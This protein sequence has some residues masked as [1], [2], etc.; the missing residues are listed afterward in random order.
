LVPDLGGAGF[1]ALLIAG[2][3]VLV[4][5]SVSRLTFLYPSGKPLEPLQGT[6][7]LSPTTGNAAADRTPAVRATLVLIRHHPWGVGPGGFRH[8]FLEVAW[9]VAPT[10]PFSLSHQAIHPGNAFLE[11]TV[12]TGLLGG[13]AFALL[14]IVLLLQAALA[15]AR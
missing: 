3:V 15:A 8:A 11:M 14:V 6:S 10:S 1:R 12:E 2:I 4:V 9:T 5:V 7:L 13:L